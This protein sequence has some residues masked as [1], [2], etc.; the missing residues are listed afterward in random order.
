MDLFG[1][2]SLCQCAATQQIESYHQG[3]G[4]GE[5]QGRQEGQGQE[6]SGAKK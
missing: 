4:R 5:R 6:G 1:G 3:R 2:A